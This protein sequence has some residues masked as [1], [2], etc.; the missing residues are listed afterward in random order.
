MAVREVSD[1]STTAYIGSINATPRVSLVGDATQNMSN[2]ANQNIESKHIDSDDAPP[3]AQKPEPYS[4][5]DR[6]QK[7]IIVFLVSVAATFSGFA[8]N[9]YLYVYPRA[10]TG[11]DID[12]RV[13]VLP[14]T[15]PV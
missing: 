13:L 2:T 3:L 1:R 6:R 14:N 12:L 7:A 10:W 4:I 5:F 15:S 9:A 8:S 11:R